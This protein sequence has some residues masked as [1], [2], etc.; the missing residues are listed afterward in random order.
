MI[1]PKYLEGELLLYHF[2]R[3]KPTWTALG[4]G[5]IFGNE[6]LAFND[7]RYGTASKIV[8]PPFR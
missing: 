1:Q 5:P 4:L 2:V 3:P 6:K 7:L 8:S